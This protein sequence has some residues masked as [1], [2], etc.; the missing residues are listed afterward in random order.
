MEE[1]LYLN[2]VD[3]EGQCKLFLPLIPLKEL[4]DC[5]LFVGWFFF[6]FCVLYERHSKCVTEIVERVLRLPRPKDKKRPSLVSF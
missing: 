1:S 5:F 4:V 6:S 3:A 2:Y